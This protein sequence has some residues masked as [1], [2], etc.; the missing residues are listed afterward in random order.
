VSPANPYLNDLSA[1]TCNGDTGFLDQPRPLQYVAC[2]ACP[3]RSLCP[4]PTPWPKGECCRR[5]HIGGKHKSGNC[6]I[7]ATDYKTGRRTPPNVT[8][9]LLQAPEPATVPVDNARVRFVVTMRNGGFGW[10]EIIRDLRTKSTALRQVL[11]EAGR[12][13]LVEDLSEYIEAR[14]L[15]KLQRS[16]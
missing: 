2:L 13:S 9:E 10:E 3:V 16:A 7:C 15:A 6:V 5:G 4:V 14:R 1:G 11:V 8:L 12:L